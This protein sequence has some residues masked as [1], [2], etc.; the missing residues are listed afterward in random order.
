MVLKP[1]KIKRS[2]EYYL[3]KIRE[4]KLD[5]EELTGKKK[6]QKQEALA[7]FRSKLK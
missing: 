2:E 5:V 7:K 1:V 6:T 3:R 4:A